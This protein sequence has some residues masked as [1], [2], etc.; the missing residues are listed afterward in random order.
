MS[1]E[2]K[3]RV[4]IQ[5]SNELRTILIICAIVLIAPLIW[6]KFT[7]QTATAAVE[8]EKGEVAVASVIHPKEQLIIKKTVEGFGV[9]AVSKGLAGWSVK[10]ELEIN[11]GDMG[12]TEVMQRT[13]RF[14]K[15]REMHVSLL[16][17]EEDSFERI[18][19]VH[20]DGSVDDFSGV[21]NEG[22]FLYFHYNERNEPVGS[23]EGQRRDGRTFTLTAKPE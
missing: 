3:K 21:S 8:K 19:A 4:I 23:F 13:F 18:A 1:E 9:Y 11:S 5:Y 16:L 12:K 22:S 17:D 7:N 15:G 10:D 2:K 20:P 6:G 14:G